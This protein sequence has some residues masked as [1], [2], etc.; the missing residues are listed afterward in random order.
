MEKSSSKPPLIANT[1]LFLQK[2]RVPSYRLTL[3]LQYISDTMKLIILQKGH[4]IMAEFKLT[5]NDK[6]YNILM[7]QLCALGYEEQLDNMTKG[8]EI[9]D[10]IDK[11]HL[12]ITKL[13]FPYDSFEA[14]RK[15][16]ES[17]EYDLDDDDKYNENYI[18]FANTKELVRAYLHGD[19]TGLLD[20]EPHIFQRLVKEIQDEES[21]NRS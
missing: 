8:M 18:P 15:T 4:F 11:E 6:K 12:D 2:Y 20:I 13:T 5:E 19:I 21:T 1:S 10:L 14:F 16:V 7:E 9:I 17:G 3:V